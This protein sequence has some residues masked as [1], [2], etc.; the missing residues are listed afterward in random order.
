MVKT[1]INFNIKLYKQKY[2]RGKIIKLNLLYYKGSGTTEYAFAVAD[3][4]IQDGNHIIY[5][6]PHSRLQVTSRISELLKILNTKDEDSFLKALKEFKKDKKEILLLVD[7]LDSI[8]INDRDSYKLLNY[9]KNLQEDNYLHTLYVFRTNLLERFITGLYNNDISLIFV[10]GNKFPDL[11]TDKE[12]EY[13]SKFCSI[14]EELAQ[15][16]LFF[17]G[18]NYKNMK[19]YN[20]FVK[21]NKETNNDLKTVEGFFLNITY[22]KSN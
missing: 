12:K 11:Q 10:G 2:K 15:K 5:Y 14:N 9:L 16:F 4:W 13:V 17:F 8:D 19:E 20:D 22:F 7:D 21:Y 1:F 6:K 3:K 18:M